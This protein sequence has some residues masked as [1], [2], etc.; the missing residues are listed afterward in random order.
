MLSCCS[1]T[2]HPRALSVGMALPW[3]DELPSVIERAVVSVDNAN[4]NRKIFVTERFYTRDPW[5]LELDGAKWCLIRRDRHW[6][7]VQYLQTE[8]P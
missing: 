3:P 8:A 6:V 1:A 4:A 7:G 5:C 2:S